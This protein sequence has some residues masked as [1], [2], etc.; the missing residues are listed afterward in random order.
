MP[1]TNKGKYMKAKLHLDGWEICCSDMA[2]ALI[3][4]NI[5]GSFVDYLGIVQ[6]WINEGSN[7]ICCPYCCK[8]LP[9]SELEDNQ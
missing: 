5:Q 6:L 4:D 3:N 8:E 9:K 2:D 1:N 7:I